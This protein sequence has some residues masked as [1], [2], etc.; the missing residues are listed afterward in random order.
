MKNERVYSAFDPQ[1]LLNRPFEVAV[2]DKSGLAGVAC[3]VQL[4]FK[5]CDI[6][7]V[8]DKTHPGIKKMHQWVTMQYESGRTTAISDR[9]MIE[10]G[11]Q[12]L[13]D[14]FSSNL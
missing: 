10:L 3:W 6:H 14:Y 4:Y 1:K 7:S 2:T 5:R 13:P 11:V 12:Y 9:E 8:V